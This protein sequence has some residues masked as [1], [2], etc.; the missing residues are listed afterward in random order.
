MATKT[1]D[2]GSIAY[3]AV[4][5]IWGSSQDLSGMTTAY[6]AVPLV[7]VQNMPGANYVMDTRGRLTNINLT[8]GNSESH[9]F[10]D[11]GNRTSVVTS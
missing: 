11:A 10:D 4:P 1:F 5:F 9:S 6:R 7:G 3:Q 2:L 8:N